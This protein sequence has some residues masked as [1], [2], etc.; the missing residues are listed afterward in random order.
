MGFIFNKKFITAL[1]ILGLLLLISC[2]YFSFKQIHQLRK[3]NQSIIYTFQFIRALNEIGLGVNRAQSLLGEHIITNAP[4][5][6]SLMELNFKKSIDNL[7]IAASLTKDPKQLD[8]LKQLRPIVLQRIT[9]LRNLLLQKISIQLDPTFAA[10]TKK[11]PALTQQNMLILME[12]GHLEENLLTKR[13]GELR[14]EE[15]QNEI[16][17]I[18]VACLSGGL[19]LLTFLLLGLHVRHLT[20]AQIKRA[21]I[22]K[23]L[24]QLNKYLQAREEQFALALHGSKIGLW[25]WSITTNTIYLSPYLMSM[26]GYGEKEI[27]TNTQY[28]NDHIHPEDR[29]LVRKALR[30]HLTKKI[31]YSVEYRLRNKECVYQWFNSSGQAIFNDDNKPTR[32]VGSLINISSR[33]QAEKELLTSES[34]KSAILKNASDAIITVDQKGIIYTT[35]PQVTKIFGYRQEELQQK[36]IELIIPNFINTL[37]KTKTTAAIEMTGVRKSGEWFPEEL[38][39]ADMKMGQATM[40]VIVIRDITER[41]RVEKMKNEFVSVVSH[42]LRTPLTSIRGSVSLLLGCTVGNFSDKAKKLLKIAENNCERL[43]LLISDILDIE[44]VEAGK[45]DFALEVIDINKLAQEAVNISQPFADKYGITLTCLPLKDILVEVEPNRLMQVLSNLI[46]NAI[47]FSPR[48]SQVIISVQKI[49]GKTVRVNVEDNGPGIS[50]EF[51]TQIF[52]KFSQADSSTSRGKG[53]TGLGLYI[54]K[55]IINRMHGDIYYKNKQGRGAVFYFDLPISQSTEQPIKKPLTTANLDIAK[56]RI[57]IC[58]DD[59]NQANYLYRLLLSAGFAVDIAA[60]AAEAKPLLL[61][62]NYHAMILDLILPDQD[63]ISFIYELRNKRKTKNLP[64]IVLSVIAQ[65]GHQIFQDDLISVIDWLDKPVDFKKLLERL[66]TIKSTNSN[67]IPAIL[68]IE[69]DKQTQELV[70]AILEPLARI[71]AVNNSNQAS[72]YIAQQ[73]FD[74]IISEINLEDGKIYKILPL[75]AQKNIPV[76]IYSENELDMQYAQYVSETL[77]KSKNSSEELLLVIKELLSSLQ[78]IKH[79]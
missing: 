77:R 48:G 44:K 65:T 17:F 72:Q 25:D 27:T 42:E 33:K 34:I 38:T 40:Y 50:P 57:L 21:A 76:V 64:I 14:K 79:A 54:S 39:I 13:Y 45:I 78:E 28:I 30:T 19:F 75:I 61:K 53:G 56:K 35:N 73:Q 6:K 62:N 66:A 67:E 49:G 11:L 58:E 47:K 71:T 52:Q 5:N 51:A 7:T 24:L 1:F 70:R 23:E 9:L 74:L 22:E 36:N 32:M 31:P 41:K 69:K 10:Q 15:K 29:H 37:E 55:T 26:L 8:Y 20:N 12:M 4:L 63:G 68:L 2:I 43:L 16:I 18:A 46:S 60:T 59:E 3:T